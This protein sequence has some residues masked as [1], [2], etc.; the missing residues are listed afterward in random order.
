MSDAQRQ[1]HKLLLQSAENLRA[2]QMSGL[3]SPYG[4]QSEKTQRHVTVALTEI[5]SAVRQIER[6]AA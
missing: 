3:T 1:I 4:A 6:D 2:V 5:W